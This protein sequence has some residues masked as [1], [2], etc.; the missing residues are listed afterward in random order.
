MWDIVHT[1]G[2]VLLAFAL[3]Y[4]L[5]NLG[6]GAFAIIRSSGS[7]RA[8]ERG[9]ATL[10]PPAGAAD[11]WMTYFLLPCLNESLV[12]GASVQD[13][14][15][16]TQDSFVVVIDDAS[17]DGTAEFARSAAE[18]VGHLDRILLVRRSLP[19]AR[20]GKGAALNRGLREI[21]LDVERRGLD[22]DRV[23]VCVLDA[24][25]RLSDGA[26]EHALLPFADQRIG[27]V[28][29]IVRIRNRDRWITLMQD[30]EF[31]C[32]SAT[33]QFARTFTGT[34][35][36]GGNGQFTRLSALQSVDG[37]PWSSSLTE[38]LDLGLRLY[39]QGWL[40]TAS[41]FGYVHQQGVTNLRTLLRQRTRWYQG[42]MSA[43]VRVPELVRSPKLGELGLLEVVLYL[44][45]PW[46]IVLPWSIIQ[47]VIL[48][49]PLV[50]P[51]SWYDIAPVSNVMAT[52]LM[53]GIWYCVC[54]LPN[55]LIGITYSRRTSAVSLAK[56]LV[57]GHAMIIYN[58]IGYVA[59]WRA[60]FR[61]CFGRVS[62]AKTPRSMEAT[63]R[64]TASMQNEVKP[65]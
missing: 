35:S 58:Y 43:I 5:F 40:V 7:L 48:L 65:S 12:I 2:G 14:L 11:S 49:A 21:T 61:M 64:A 63:S 50:D 24:D 36:L 31:W 34:V 62:W 59:A 41:P 51:A 42:H 32:I 9:A 23:I 17:D 27:A 25:G 38:D 46:L 30:V 26:L 20:L 19:D 47:Q 45:V 53:W 37:E 52:V 18:E 60:F 15:S 39:A 33:A 28:Q 6:I 4:F 56:A 44:L 13:L 57:L 8:Q 16:R 22:V 3:P 54:F 10:P 1:V 29:L 55:L